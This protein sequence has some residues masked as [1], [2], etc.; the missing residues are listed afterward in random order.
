MLSEGSCPGDP[1][2]AAALAVPTQEFVATVAGDRQVGAA[3]SAAPPGTVAS[4]ALGADGRPWLCG[5]AWLVAF[6]TSSVGRVINAADAVGGRPK[7]AA[8][9]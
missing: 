6:Q 8:T 3:R 4:E 9:V 5:S 2:E 7:G 1:G